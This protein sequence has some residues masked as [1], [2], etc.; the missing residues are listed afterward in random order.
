MLHFPHFRDLYATVETVSTHEFAVFEP[1]Q[2]ELFG[3]YLDKLM[4]F[5][6]K[7]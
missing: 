6:S 3:N 5:S 7:Q 1:G 2:P 4:G